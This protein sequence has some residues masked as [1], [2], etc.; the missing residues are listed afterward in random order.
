MQHRDGCHKVK[1]FLH[2][3]PLKPNSP[4]PSHFPS[5]L[6][7]WIFCVWLAI[8][9]KFDLIFPRVV[10]T[11]TIWAWPRSCFRS[12]FLLMP[13]LAPISSICNFSYQHSYGKDFQDFCVS[14]QYTR[15]C[16]FNECFTVIYKWLQYFEFRL[17]YYMKY[18]S[19]WC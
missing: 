10:V 18:E 1:C 7:P 16:K 5:P 11:I 12:H 17:R 13:L 19:A 14:K 2:L 3:E 4:S 15:Q 8:F 9:E 6:Y